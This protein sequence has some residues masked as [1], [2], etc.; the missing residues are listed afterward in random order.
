MIES[1][2]TIASAI[3][4]VHELYHTFSGYFNE[5]RP[6]LPCVRCI[7]G[8]NRTPGFPT[9]ELDKFLLLSTFFQNA[10]LTLPLPN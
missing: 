10:G 5:T 9:A 7:N 8:M 4:G 3:S 1:K 2:G 6:D